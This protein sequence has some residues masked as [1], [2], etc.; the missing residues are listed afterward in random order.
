MA[1]FPLARPTDASLVV[2][3]LFLFSLFVL[4]P[5]TLLAQGR[6][7]GRRPGGPA[8]AGQPAGGAGLTLRAIGPAV[9]SGRVIAFAVDPNDSTLRGDL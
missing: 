6:A 8:G 7:G 5:G 1:S 2:R 3:T 4:L 9:T